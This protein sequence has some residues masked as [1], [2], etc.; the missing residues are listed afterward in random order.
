MSYADENQRNDK[1][2]ND[3]VV[4]KL[5]KH[6]EDLIRAMALM[7]QAYNILNI[8]DDLH[9][10]WGHESHHKKAKRNLFNDVD[11]MSWFVEHILNNVGSE[12]SAYAGNI[13]AFLKPEEAERLKQDYREGKF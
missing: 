12:H 3:A 10:D 5:I 6:R 8:T 9:G 1:E 13:A 7:N 11:R 4:A 2:L